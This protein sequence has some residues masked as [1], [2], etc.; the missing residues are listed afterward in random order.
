MEIVPDIPQGMLQVGSTI[1]GDI[2]LNLPITMP[3]G[4][5]GTSHTIFNSA[6]AKQLADALNKLASDV[7]E[8]YAKA[9]RV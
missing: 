6:Q 7:D 8:M 9:V 4:T 5:P 2:F 3:D 1:M